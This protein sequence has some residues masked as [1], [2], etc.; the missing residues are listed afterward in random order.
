MIVFPIPLFIAPIV[1]AGGRLLEI[2]LEHWRVVLVLVLLAAFALLGYGYQARGI[3]IENLKAEVKSAEARTRI[4]VDAC[5]RQ[6]AA[7][8]KWEETNASFEEALAEALSKP[9]EIIEVIR[10]VAADIPPPEE[11]PED[12]GEA[13][14]EV[15]KVLQRLCGEESK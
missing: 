5:D 7:V 1:K 14:I 4:W 11:M 3:E 12:P 15:G 10:E 6:T 13:I 2:L 9:P 8:T